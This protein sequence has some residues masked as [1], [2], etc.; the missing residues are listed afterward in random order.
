MARKHKKMQTTRFLNKAQRGTKTDGF[1]NGKFRGLS[2]LAILAQQKNMGHVWVVLCHPKGYQNRW[3]SGQ[4]VL[5]TFK[6][7]TFGAP[8]IVVYSWV[9]PS[10]GTPIFD[11]PALSGGMDCW[12][13]ELPFCRARFFFQSP[14]S[15]AKSLTFRSKSD[16]HQIFCV[17]L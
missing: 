5:G 8:A 11:R 13:M 15:A 14:N 2:K 10:L 9:F 16:F 12:R 3:F 4:H 6:T 1:Q 17:P 7:R